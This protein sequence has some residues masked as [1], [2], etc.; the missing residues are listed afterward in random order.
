MDDGEREAATAGAAD[1][2][3]RARSRLGADWTW[4]AVGA[5]TAVAAASRATGLTTLGLWRDDAWVALVGRVGPGM[6]WH[7]S[8]TAPLFALGTWGWLHLGDPATAWWAQLPPLALGVAAVPATYAV[9][10]WYR[11]PPAG[12]LVAAAIVAAGPV[13]ITYSVR[14]KPYGLDLLVAC[15]LLVAGDRARRRRSAGDLAVLAG[16]AVLG[17]AASASVAPAVAGALVGVALDAAWH[18]DRW[19][20]AALGVAAGA[21][22]TAAV[23]LVGYRRLPPGIAA[24]LHPF[25]VDASSPTDLIDTAGTAAQRVLAGLAPE[26]T[27]LASAPPTVVLLIV[28]AVVGL[29]L[30]AGREAW[31][32][33]L[34][35]AASA[36]AAA[37]RL[38]PIGTGRL[39]QVLYPSLLVLGALAARELG[40]R[41]IPAEQRATP[42]ARILGRGTA[43]LAVVALCLRALTAPADYPATD[44]AAL[45][46]LVAERAQPGDLVVVDARTRYLWALT[47]PDTPAI[48]LGDRW[49]TGFTVTAN[50]PGVTFQS[51]YSVEEGYTPRRWA[52]DAEGASRILYVSTPF[53]IPEEASDDAYA[54]LRRRG[55]EPA[56]V[57]DVTGG[58]LVVLDRAG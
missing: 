37:A 21:A 15:A 5:V 53:E 7:M 49:L 33:A 35:V 4:L 43:A 39:D 26:G 25:Y 50:E 22:G 9:Q 27:G 44:I 41:A 23:Y 28:V 40:R 51:S 13:A 46:D 58:R 55:W 20:P 17:F 8:A 42:R 34:T 6:A 2:L 54:E 47:Q 1:R 48:V 14:L 38:A 16:V 11:I 12:A 3:R 18:R 57:V 30:L 45:R 10:R 31:I 24:T 36:V 19:R 56:E 32:P 29:G 52:D